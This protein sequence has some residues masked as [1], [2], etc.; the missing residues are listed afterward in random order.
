MEYK[1]SGTLRLIIKNKVVEVHSSYEKTDNR[2]CGNEIIGID[3]GYSE[4]F[5]T[6]TNEFLG[7]DL[8]KILTQYSDKLKVKYQRRNKLLAL[9]KKAQKKQST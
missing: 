9:M 8:G 5:A 6:S 7:K 4:V 1:P 2:A 3:K